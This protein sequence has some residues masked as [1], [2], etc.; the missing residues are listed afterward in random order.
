MSVQAIHVWT[1]ASALTLPT[2]WLTD[3][4]VNPVILEI[5]AK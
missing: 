1:V 2:T 4:H 3:V 5:D